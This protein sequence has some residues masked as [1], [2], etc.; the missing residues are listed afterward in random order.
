LVGIPG[1][2]GNLVSSLVDVLVVFLVVTVMTN[3]S[4][5]LIEGLGIATPMFGPPLATVFAVVVLSLFR[6]M[7]CPS[8]VAYVG[9]TL[10]ALVGAD[11]LNLG[12]IRE[13]GAPVVSI[14]GAGTFDGV[15]LTGVFSVV[16]VLLL[17]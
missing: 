6:V 7:W 10:G 8:Q 9:G 5:R 17:V 1:C 2:S 16:L 14:G 13:L 12:R 4:S 11:L 15:Y 3:R